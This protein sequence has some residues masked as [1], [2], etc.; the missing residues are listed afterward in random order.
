MNRAQTNFFEYH[1]QNPHVYAEYLRFAKELHAA[2][3]QRKSISMITER[4]R[5]NTA[6]RGEGD[7]KINNTL[8]AGYSRLLIWKN[9]DFQYHGCFRLKKSSIDGVLG[10]DF[11]DFC[12]WNSG[13]WNLF[14]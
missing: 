9:T 2:G 6:T 10:I 3:V 11:N 13:Y 5:W 7:F 12:T 1:N 14:K 4:I 8:R